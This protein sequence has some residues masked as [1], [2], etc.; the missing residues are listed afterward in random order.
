MADRYRDVGTRWRE[1]CRAN[2]RERQPELP[3]RR[4]GK[5]DLLENDRGNYH[6]LRGISPY[7]GGVAATSGHEIV[8]VTLEN[9]VPYRRGFDAIETHLEREGRAIAALCAI[10]LRL[11][12]QLVFEGFANL[13]A[14]Y[15]A[16]LREYGLLVGDTNPIARTAVVPVTDPPP[17]PSVS[18]FS[19]TCPSRGAPKSYVLSGAGEL[20]DGVLS[21]A[22]IVQ[23]GNVSAAVVLEKASLVLGLL[24]VRLEGLK[25]RERSALQTNVYSKSAVTQDILGL[26]R[27][28]FPSVATCGIHWFPSL[29]PIAEL[30]FEMDARSVR[31]QIWA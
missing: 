23:R 22:A 15:E 17:V 24:Q 2:W 16:V 8:H 5:L 13:N 19:F 18:G 27:Q 9:P 10:E 1:V 3:F 29:P 25:V 4:G 12:Q 7:S 26:I 30:C 21:P 6:F 20:V 31:R 28:V 14:E 11:P